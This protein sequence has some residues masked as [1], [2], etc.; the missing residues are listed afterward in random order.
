MKGFKGLDLYRKAPDGIK[1]PT[2]RGGIFSVISLCIVIGLICYQIDKYYFDEPLPYM[3]IDSLNTEE[4]LS[5]FV[6]ITFHSLQCKSIVLHYTDA[7]GVHN[8]VRTLNKISLDKKGKPLVNRDGIQDLVE[9]VYGECGSC[10][11]AEL[12]ENQCCNTCDEVIEAYNKKKWVPPS[13]DNIPQCTKGLIID[14]EQGT[15]C[16]LFGSFHVPK[17]PG[18]FHFKADMAWMPST[19]D[20][21]TGNHT[22]HNLVF[23]DLNT[24]YSDDSKLSLLV[25]QG[26]YINYYLK[27]ISTLKNQRKYYTISSNHLVMPTRQMPEIKFYY[28]TESIM[29]VYEDKRRFSEFIVSICAIV[30]GWFALSRFLSVF[31]IKD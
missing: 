24:S 29:T 21:H 1:V 5:V 9:P 11:G 14:T 2:L 13:F 10:F 28:E 8:V 7:K 16:R 23:Y 26:F 25:I 27:I 20:K 22:I 17:I 18:N 4:R 30:G 3:T 31:I 12:Y 19:G 15:G 6:N